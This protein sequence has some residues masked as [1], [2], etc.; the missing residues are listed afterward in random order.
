MSENKSL[1]KPKSKSRKLENLTNSIF[2]SRKSKNR[3]SHST[4][5]QEQK[6]KPGHALSCVPWKIWSSS[7]KIDDYFYYEQKE[8]E[9]GSDLFEVD[10]ISM[11]KEDGSCQKNADEEGEDNDDNLFDGS[12]TAIETIKAWKKAHN[13]RVIQKCLEEKKIFERAD[14]KKDVRELNRHLDKYRLK[15][16]HIL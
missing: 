4:V 15:T 14:M 2:N 9:N 3:Y 11:I 12:D 6:W 10:H 1:L 8:E 16:S 7:K 13:L 5:T